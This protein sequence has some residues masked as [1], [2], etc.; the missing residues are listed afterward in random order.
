[1]ERPHLEKFIGQEVTL[2]FK[3]GD[4]T[5]GRL[6]WTSQYEPLVNGWLVNVPGRFFSFNG[7]FY[8]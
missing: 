1:M 5:T 4:T 3:N 7:K 8:D 2:H 6:T